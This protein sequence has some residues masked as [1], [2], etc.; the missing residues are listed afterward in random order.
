MIADIQGWDQAGLRCG[1]CRPGFFRHAA[2]AVRRLL[3]ACR[4]LLPLRL[5]ER[6]GISE[7]LPGL[8]N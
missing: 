7:P 1:V 3:S 8:M 4:P 6:F 2:A 5:R